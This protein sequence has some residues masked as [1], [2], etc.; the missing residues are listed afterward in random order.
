MQITPLFY[1]FQNRHKA[2]VHEYLKE[3][4]TMAMFANIRDIKDKIVKQLRTLRSLGEMA[5]V[6][7]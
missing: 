6:M 4:Q 3:C 2:L 7:R 1:H 5:A